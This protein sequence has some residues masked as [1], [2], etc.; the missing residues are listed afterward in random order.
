[1]DL[2][3]I[4]SFL[5]V[6]EHGSFKGASD[7]LGASRSTLRRHIQELEEASSCAL[8]ER[9]EGDLKPTQPGQLLL[10][11]ARTLEHELEGLFEEV[12]HMGA[13]PT[14]TVRA[15]LPVG[16]SPRLLSAL[17]GHLRAR[18]PR[19]QLALNFSE[20]PLAELSTDYDLVCYVGESLPEGTWMV[21]K[22]MLIEEILFASE[23]HLQRHGMPERPEDLTRHPIMT[24]DR[25]GADP[26]ELPLWDGG[27]IRVDPMLIS[28]D[29]SLLQMACAAGRG[30]ALMPMTGAP[31]PRGMKGQ[32]HPVLPAFIGAS[33]PV[34]LVWPEGREA[35]PSL[36]IVLD[37][38][39]AMT[40]RWDTVRDFSF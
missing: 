29:L 3:K 17:L 34:R 35:T 30:L 6:V 40:S 19:L 39:I 33:R 15:L 22:L 18:L 10:N 24:W 14:G 27:G 9:V 11:H 28:P 36:R 20:N 31:E 1:M 37:T 26:H 2:D 21:R 13:N 7:A 5:A 23:D 16:L 4:R 38:L 32:L 25:A 8:L 12:R